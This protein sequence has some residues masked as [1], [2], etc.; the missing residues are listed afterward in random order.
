M[1]DQD[2]GPLKERDAAIVRNVISELVESVIAECD[3]N[4][5][6]VVTVVLEREWTWYAHTDASAYDV[7]TVTMGDFK[8]INEFFRLYNH[9]PSPSQVFMGA[10]TLFLPN[11]NGGCNVNGYAIFQKGVLPAWEDVANMHGC[12]IC[13]RTSLDADAIG[14]IWLDLSISLINEQLGDNVLGVRLTHRLDRKTN[15]VVH[16][17]EVWLKDQDNE[18]VQNS[19]VQAVE[20][21]GFYTWS[22][23]QHSTVSYAR[24]AVRTR[25]RK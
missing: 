7:G 14:E 15:E 23:V 22:V 3:C 2:A 6:E 17:I 16:K 19:M 10:S 8:T 11:V 18:A 24:P 4:I 12:D 20:Q 25:R 1:H 13:A 5:D 9:I 21:L